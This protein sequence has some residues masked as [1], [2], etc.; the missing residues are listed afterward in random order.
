[1]FINEVGCSGTGVGVRS[2]KWEGEEVW[3]GKTGGGRFD[4]TEVV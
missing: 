4:E 3:V 2:R 1:M